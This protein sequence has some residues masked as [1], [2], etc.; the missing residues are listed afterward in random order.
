MDSCFG[1]MNS[2]NSQAGIETKAIREITDIAFKR[3]VRLGRPFIWIQGCSPTRHGQAET[4]NGCHS[5]NRQHRWSGY[6]LPR[7]RFGREPNGAFAAR[8]PD[9]VADVPKPDAGTGKRL[10]PGRPRLP[11]FRR[12]LFTARASI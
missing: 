3:C 7:S 5:Q 4:T 11:G 2:K 1:L 9:F 10:P 12:K 6:L 8:F